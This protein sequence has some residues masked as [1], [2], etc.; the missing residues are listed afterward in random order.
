MKLARHTIFNLLGLGLP[1]LF[2]LVTIPALVQA[3]GHER[4]GLLTL[5]WAITSYFGLLDLGLGRALTQQLAVVLDQKRD[6]DVGPL[7]ASALM[8]MA[9]V[10]V[11]G[12]AL[13]IMLAPWGVGLIKQLPDPQEAVQATLIMGLATPFIVLTAGLRGMLEA[14]HAF[15]ALNY[16]R[17]PMGL[18]TFAGP[19]FVVEVWGP[20]LV[21]ITLVLAVGRALAA[22]VHGWVAWRRL[23]QMRGRLEVQRRW[24]K[25]LLRSGG[26]LTL[27]NVVS[28]LMGYADRFVIGVAVSAA[29]VAYYAT[30][31][32]IVTK[33]WIVPGALTAVLFP[34]FAAQVV[35]QD[36]SSWQLYDRAVAA[37]FVVLLPI[38]AGLALFAGE[39][40]QAWLGPA[41][42]RES[43]LILQIFALGILINCLAHVPLTWLHGAGHFRAPALLHC[44]ELPLFLMA[45][46]G[47]CRHGGLLGAALAWLLRISADAALLFWLV[48]RERRAQIPDPARPARIWPLAVGS[49]AFAGLAWPGL[50]WRGAWLLGVLAAVATMAF[51]LRAELRT[52]S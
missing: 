37:L 40:L 43:T 48:R 3:L 15:E 52:T 34:A 26:W 39:L 31:Q 5:I 33:L 4:F 35:K 20:D 10:G 21:W 2:A 19:W 44:I 6:I 41:F 9:L 25:P 28:P 18:W 22:I 42:A 45:L 24:L 29:A 32:E 12:G 46:W 50:L 1:L 11:L 27:S 49:L 30:P 38:C 14:C 51:L 8:C 17:L 13:M 36:G 16:I 47:L 23:P 7:C